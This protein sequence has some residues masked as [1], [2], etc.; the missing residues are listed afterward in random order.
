M[1]AS[2]PRQVVIIVENKYITNILIPPISF[3]FYFL[4]WDK[5][6]MMISLSSYSFL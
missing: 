6:S 2:T 3:F 4:F 1:M 5:D